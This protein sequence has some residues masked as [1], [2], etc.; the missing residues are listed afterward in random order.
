MFKTGCA[1]VGFSVDYPSI[2]T[3]GMKIKRNHIAC[4]LEG[5][6][7]VRSC[8]I[9]YDDFLF[10]FFVFLFS[11]FSFPLLEYGMCLCV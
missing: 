3:A 6:D 9:Y 2:I 4:I 5:Y 8:K 7:F 1:L 10:L 11:L